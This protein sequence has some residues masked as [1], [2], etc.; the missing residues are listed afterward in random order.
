MNHYK[1]TPE[2]FEERLSV[3]RKVYGECDELVNDSLHEYKRR[4]LNKD[5]ILDALVAV[6]TARYGINALKTIPDVPELDETGL[7]MEMV[8]YTPEG[9]ILK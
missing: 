6:V 8:Y 5:D 2:G 1:R 9:K 3:I 4:D 7:P